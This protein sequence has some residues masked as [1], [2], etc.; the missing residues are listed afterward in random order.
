MDHPDCQAVEHRMPESL[1]TDMTEGC[2]YVIRHV[3]TGL[4]L[5]VGSCV[6]CAHRMRT[7]QRTH[8]C[9]YKTTLQRH[10]EDNG[11]WCRVAVKT[12][13]VV[14]RSYR[15]RPIGVLISTVVHYEAQTRAMKLII[16]HA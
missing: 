14:Q 10:V 16:M 8:S 12:P 11:G 2:V 7:H 9:G 5:Y 6:E 15:P 1:P 4:I 13:Q 3:V